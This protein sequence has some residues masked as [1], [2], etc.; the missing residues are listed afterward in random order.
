MLKA[1]SVA[2]DRLL[3]LHGVAILWGRKICADQQN[4]VSARLISQQRFSTR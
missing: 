2:L 1:P 4:I 3:E